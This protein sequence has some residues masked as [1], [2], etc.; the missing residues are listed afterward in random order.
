MAIKSTSKDQSKGHASHTRV[1][2]YALEPRILF[3]AAATATADA[4]VAD[5]NNP[6]TLTTDSAVNHETTLVLQALATHVANIDQISRD[7][8]LSAA[9][10]PIESAL[11][12]KSVRLFEVATVVQPAPDSLDEVMQHAQQL[13]TDFLQ[14]PDAKQQLFDLFNGGQTEPSQEWLDA[15]NSLIDDYQNQH[16]LANVMVLS[17]K[18]IQG[19]LGAFAAHGPDGSSTIYLNSD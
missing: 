13:I 10:T 6:G 2:S 1:L 18:D 11:T 15:A 16:N 17:N 14:R 19:A 12:D 7:P 5:A 3:D 4:T 9:T 8:V